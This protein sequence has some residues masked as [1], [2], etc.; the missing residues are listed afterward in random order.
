MDIEFKSVG[1]LYERL[2]PALATKEY[3]LKRNG[4]SYIKKEDVWNYL[5]SYKWKSSN[6]L[7]LFQMVD[8]ILNIDDILLKNYIEKKFSNI[9]VEPK[10]ESEGF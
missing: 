2:I 1:E 5:T 6:S 10:L 8:D 7:L 3:E 9:R 4:Y